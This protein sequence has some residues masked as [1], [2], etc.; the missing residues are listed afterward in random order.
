MSK[1]NPQI[2]Q[3]GANGARR[4]KA[5]NL[6]KLVLSKVEVSALICGSILISDIVYFI[7]VP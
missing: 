2:S 1:N 4:L 3:I 5:K 7:R 6:R